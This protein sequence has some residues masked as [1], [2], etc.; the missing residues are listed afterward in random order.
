MA[1]KYPFVNVIIQKVAALDQAIRSTLAWAAT[2]LI[3]VSA[4]PHVVIDVAR[5]LTVE[6]LDAL[7]TL[8][9]NYV[10]PEEFLVFNRTET[11]PMQS[12]FVTDP[13][14]AVV[15]GKSALQTFIFVNQNQPA[16]VLD[17]IKTIVE[18]R[19]L[20]DSVALADISITLEV[21]D[22][23][24]SLLIATHTLS[25]DQVTTWSSDSAWKSVFFGGLYKKTPTHD[26]IW[27]IRGSISHPSNVTFRVH[28][29][30]YIFYDVA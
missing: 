16:T 10:D 25:L 21:Y 1:T 7:T 6:E 3:G 27:Q 30:Q 22:V 19:R 8:V 24:R 13:L 29:L 26:C 15:D 23:T 9:N 18:Y 20:D 12:T 11:Y 5:A 17:S 28:S 4:E 2:D 14:N